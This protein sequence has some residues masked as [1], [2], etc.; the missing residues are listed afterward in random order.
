MKEPII[1]ATTVAG[2]DGAQPARA[3]PTIAIDDSLLASFE[4]GTREILRA[5][6]DLVGTLEARIA[7]L[8]ERL[9]EDELTGILN[10]RGF[11]R[12]LDRAIAF[13][14]RY[15]TPASIVYIDINHFKAINDRHGHHVGDLVLCHVA[16]VLSENV[17]QSDIVGRLSGDEFV[18]LLWSADEA[19]AAR[20]A[21]ELVDLVASTPVA[22]RDRSVT[23]S[24]SYGVAALHAEDTEAS[25]LER[26][27]KAM[28]VDKKRNHERDGSPRSG[29]DV[30]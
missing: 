29:D 11:A 12:E 23:V 24:L 20:K 17:R 9:D 21:Q 15:E 5:F 6:G 8:E 10:R 27:D 1:P 16:K 30:G 18:L 2:A 4:P 26:A 25:V 3:T 28:Y 7:T 14:T 13:S 19:A 22:E